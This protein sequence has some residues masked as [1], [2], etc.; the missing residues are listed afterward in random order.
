MTH[1]RGPDLR[2]V[3][4]VKLRDLLEP[5][6][7]GKRLE[8]SGVMATTDAFYVIFD[9]ST[10]VVRV[11]IGMSTAVVANRPAKGKRPP[12]DRESKGFEDIAVDPIDGRFFMLIE[13]R[14]RDGAFMAQVQEYDGNLVYHATRWLHFRLDGRDKGLEGL[15]CVRKKKQTYLLGLCEGNRCLSGEAGRRPGGGRVQIFRAT[16]CHWDHV[17]TIPLPKTLPFSDY[18]SIAVTG[19]RIA[20]LSQEVSALWIGAFLPGGWE[21]ADDGRIHR[22]PRDS[23]GRITYCNVEGVSWLAV[24]K[25]VVVSDRAKKKSQPEYCRDKDQSIH[26]FSIA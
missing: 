3:R 23:T 7:K 6:W 24:D 19:N 15:T 2:L 14:S 11:D 16:R 12:T 18:S 25:I 22:F 9:N 20:V 13:A 5:V 17:G 26:V 4:E 8:A 1:P 21:L 10:D